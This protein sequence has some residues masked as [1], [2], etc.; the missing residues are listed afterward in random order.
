MM[1][2]CTENSA[3]VY[4]Y[5]EHTECLEACG[6][7]PASDVAYSTSDPLVSDGNH[8]QC[9]LFHVTS[10]AMLDTEEHCEHAVGVTLCSSEPQ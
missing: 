10:A 3:Q 1:N 5:E 9:R 2:V 7:L 4:H 8:V 6:E